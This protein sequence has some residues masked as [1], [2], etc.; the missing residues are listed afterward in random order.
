M[1]T[2]IAI[3]FVT[4]ATHANPEPS[5]E[6]S[7]FIN[8]PLSLLDWGMYQVKEKLKMGSIDQP[9]VIYDWERNKIIISP[10]IDFRPQLGITMRHAKEKCEK[11][12]SEFDKILMVQPKID[13]FCLPCTYFSQIGF[14]NEDL[15]NE[16]EELVHRFYYKMHVGVPGFT[17]ERKV[18]DTSITVIEGS[19]K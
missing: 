18:Y 1:R 2:I 10:A 12:F 5:N 4:M 13:S 14:T 19:S 9:S 7:A 16:A 17:C 8:R 11:Q 6:I 15:I 3:I